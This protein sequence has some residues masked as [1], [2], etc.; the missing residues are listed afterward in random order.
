MT[1]LWTYFQGDRSQIRA[2]TPTTLWLP[3]A[4]VGAGLP[5][6][7]PRGW[8]A[9]RHRCAR[10]PLVSAMGVLYTVPSID[11]FLALPEFLGTK[12]LAPVNVVVA[13]T[14]H[15][16]ALLVPTAA[17]GLDS[18]PATTRDSAATMGQT[19]WQRLLRVQLPRLHG[20]VEVGFSEWLR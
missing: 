7:L 12:I 8:L 18:I 17:D 15:S 3:A 10:V 2:W 14:L 5:I 13:L 11:M 16:F 4:A 19:P 6:A 9:H 1:A 20:K